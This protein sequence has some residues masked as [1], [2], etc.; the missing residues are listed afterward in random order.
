M[1]KTGKPE[2]PPGKPPV[3]P[4]VDPDSIENLDIPDEDYDPYNDPDVPNIHEADAILVE[5]REHGGKSRKFHRIK[6]SK[7]DKVERDKKR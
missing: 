2:T 1:A 7:R 4:P 3:E 5:M 6:K